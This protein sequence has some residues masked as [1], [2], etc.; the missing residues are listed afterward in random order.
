M[1]DSQWPPPD[2]PN[3]RWEYIFNNTYYDWNMN[4]ILDLI[5]CQIDVDTKS[6]SAIKSIF[7]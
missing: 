7:K 2:D 1:D 5:N 3:A 6:W 4:G